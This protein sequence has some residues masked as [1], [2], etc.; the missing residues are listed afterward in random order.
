M[1]AEE[2]ERERERE[3]LEQR[4]KDLCLSNLSFRLILR[5]GAA[6]AAADESAKNEGILG[7]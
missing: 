5:K 3:A 2:R 4:K 6:A 7:L 1:R